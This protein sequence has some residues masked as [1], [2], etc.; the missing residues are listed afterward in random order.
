MFFAQIP[1]ELILF[2][3]LYGGAA[4]AGVI[5]CIYLCLRK[6]NAFAADVTPPVSLRR[7]A[8]AFFA[9]VFLGHVWWYLFYIYSGDIHSL[10]CLVVAI[11]DSVSLL[12][13]IVGTLLAMLQD[14]KRPVWPVVL[15][16]IPYAV[17]M[18]LN[19]VYPNGHFISIAIAYILLLYVLFSIYMVFAVRQYGR[20]LRDN[21]AD[22]EHKEV[23]L[24]H[25]LVI[26]ILL[27]IIIYGF[28]TGDMTIG[29]L[30][31]FIDLVLIG[32]LLWRVET[33]PQLENIS[34]EQRTQQTL[35]IPSNIEQLLAERCVST[36]LYLQHD[37]TIFQLAQAVGI[38]RL[39]LSHYFSRHGTTYN[40]YINDLRIN[41]FMS[42]YREATAARQ[43]ITAQQ[44]ASDSGYRSY[45]TFSLAFKQ[46][47]GKSVTAWMRETAK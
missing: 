11:I 43:P 26:V 19:I 38:N 5:A 7:W 28:D 29:F 17:F 30:V 6:G 39:Y 13:T 15:A 8:A 46:R 22:L 20:W 44:L 3:M 37:L 47:I 21:Y 27:F 45:S 23:W 24:S 18:A 9:V 34:M 33:L 36:Q 42:L 41:H 4:V 31:Q 16:T 40:A 12:T 14:R 25:V 10:S 2:S 35:V 1:A 32:L